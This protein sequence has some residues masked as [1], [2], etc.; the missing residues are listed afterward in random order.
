MYS[1][2]SI[3]DDTL[4]LE[5]EGRIISF[6]LIGEE[7]VRFKVLEKGADESSEFKVS[8]EKTPAKIKVSS[9][10]ED[11]FRI[12]SGNTDVIINLNPLSFKVY[13]DREERF[14]TDEVVFIDKRGEETIFR[15]RLTPEERVYGLGQDHMADLNQ[16]GKER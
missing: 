10:S 14:S 11:R 3:T 9:I 15:F 13:R 16:R 2:S 8:E 12:S 4:I 1:V 5:G 7:I 6:S